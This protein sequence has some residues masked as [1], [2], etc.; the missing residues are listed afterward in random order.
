MGKC[1]IVDMAE[2]QLAVSPLKIRVCR[3]G[4]A[5]ASM[6]SAIK[7]ISLLTMKNRTV[8]LFLLYDMIYPI[9]E[10]ACMFHRICLI[11]NHQTPYVQICLCPPLLISSLSCLN[12]NQYLYCHCILIFN[13]LVRHLD[14][15]IPAQVHLRI[16]SVLMACLDSTVRPLRKG[17]TQ[18][19]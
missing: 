10:E 5:R 8:K 16:P 6:S 1:D 13:L 15:P 7:T 12:D 11:A 9:S 18:P 4:Y 17:Q 3:E 2:T 14:H 19:Q